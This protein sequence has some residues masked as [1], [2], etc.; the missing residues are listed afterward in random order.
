MRIGWRVTG[1]GYPPHRKI[2]GVFVI[3]RGFL[4][5][6]LLCSAVQGVFFCVRNH[7]RCG[8][9]PLL[10]FLAWGK[11]EGALR[12]LMCCMLL[13]ALVG[14]VSGA[15]NVAAEKAGI[16]LPE[17]IAVGESPHSDC[18]LT[19]VIGKTGS[20]RGISPRCHFP[21]VNLPAYYICIMFCKI[22]GGGD[23]CAPS[24]EA[25]LTVRR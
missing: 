10:V 18:G 24:C 4:S 21:I 5:G 17:K 3:S 12:K 1:N 11:I 6:S 20:R 7:N 2:H 15:G 23:S 14:T 19:R 9:V 25:R 13:L 8:G 16:A 22:G